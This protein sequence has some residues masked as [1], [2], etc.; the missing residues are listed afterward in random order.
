M[1]A[2]ERI[3]SAFSNDGAPEIGV[4]V[5]YEDIYVRD[6]WEDLTSCPWWYRHSP[7]IEKQIEWWSEVRQFLAIDWFAVPGFYS[8]DERKHMLIEHRADGPYLVDSIK[9]QERKI[10]RP[11]VGGWN[12]EGAMESARPE[13]PPDTFDEIDRRITVPADPPG[14]IDLEGR[15]DLARALFAGPARDLYPISHVSSPI[16]NCYGLWGFEGLMTRVA[17]RR[18]LVVHAS[19]RLLARQMRS[20]RRAAAMGARAIWIEECLTD[21]IHPDEFLALNV[22]LIS[23]MV[24]AVRDEGMKSIYY[25]CGDPS[26]KLD[27]ILSTGA[28]AIAFEEGKK[29]FEIDIEQVSECVNGRCVLLGNLDA[30]GVLQNGSDDE[31]RSEI[32][33]QIG[34]GH[35]NGSRFIMSIGSPV[36]PLTPPERLKLYCDL[37]HDIGGQA[38]AAS[39]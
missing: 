28:D 36:T 33:G 35:R 22:P 3:E 23:R 19:E 8:R 38:T 29:G 17:E 15:D 26:G 37:A 6:R 27:H 2:A 1:T 13:N 20:I 25:Y 39:S 7:D 24:D 32:E 9:D 30:V 10:E 18:E 16:W 21:M 34:V 5:P 14:E 11:I 4:V 31:L 12:R